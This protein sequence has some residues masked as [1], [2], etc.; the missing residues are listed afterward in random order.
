MTDQPLGRLDPE[1][2]KEERSQVDFGTTEETGHDHIT[3]DQ[4]RAPGDSDDP[5]TQPTGGATPPAR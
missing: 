2:L 3:R 1:K 4:G 5:V